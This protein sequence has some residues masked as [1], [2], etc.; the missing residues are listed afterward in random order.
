MGFYK[1]LEL[2]ERL[3]GG[4][5]TSGIAKQCSRPAYWHLSEWC[6]WPTETRANCDCT[7]YSLIDNI[8]I[9]ECKSTLWYQ[10][11]RYIN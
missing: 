2:S 10:P 7:K 3:G 11:K 4:V 5:S 8:I 1:R 6:K 9:W